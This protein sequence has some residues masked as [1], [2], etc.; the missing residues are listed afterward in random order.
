MQD[1]INDL[2]KELNIDRQ[3]LSKTQDR[4]ETCSEDELD[5][6]I[7]QAALLRRTI[8]TQQ[9]QITTLRYL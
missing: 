9:K 6:I 5:G 1:L 3:A 2:I 7:Q 8:R 4:F